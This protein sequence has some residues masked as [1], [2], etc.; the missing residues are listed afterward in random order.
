CR[1]LPVQADGAVH[2]RVRGGDQAPFDLQVALGQ[3]VER[4]LVVTRAGGRR[5]GKGDR[6]RPPLAAGRPRG[7]SVPWLVRHHSPGARSGAGR[8]APR[9]PAAARTAGTAGGPPPPSRPP[10][11]RTPAPPP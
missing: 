6:P 11:W 3:Q 9:R 1:G 5:V 7:R 8:C 2:G 10:P 4:G